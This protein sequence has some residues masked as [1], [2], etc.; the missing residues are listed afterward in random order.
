MLNL[1][2]LVLFLSCN[3]PGNQSE[4]ID[5]FFKRKDYEYQSKKKWVSH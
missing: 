4:K 2:E 3:P 5:S 1:T